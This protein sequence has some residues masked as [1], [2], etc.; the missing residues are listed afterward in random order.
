MPKKISAQYD[1][2]DLDY[3][4]VFDVMQRVKLINRA[5]EK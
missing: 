5:Y 2:K 4:S 1:S 3:I